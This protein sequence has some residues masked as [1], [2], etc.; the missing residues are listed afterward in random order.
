MTFWQFVD[1]VPGEPD[2]A[3]RIGQTARLHAALREYDGDLGF[4]APF[5]TYIPDGLAELEHLPD[6]LSA[7]DL[8][9]AQREWSVIA[10]VL[11][12][13]RVFEQTFHKRCDRIRPCGGGTRR[14]RGLRRCRNGARPSSR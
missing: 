9:R 6:L 14:P 7:A 5:G 10:P 1:E 12:S 3:Y 4:W 13:Q 11:T 8:E 2:T